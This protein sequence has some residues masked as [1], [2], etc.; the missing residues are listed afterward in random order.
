MRRY[1]SIWLVVAGG[2]CWFAIREKFCWLAAVDGRFW[3]GTRKKHCWLFDWQARWTERVTKAGSTALSFLSCEHVQGLMPTF[4]L[5]FSSS[6]SYLPFHCFIQKW[7]GSLESIHGSWRGRSLPPLIPCRS[8]PFRVAVVE[9]P[10]L[11]AHLGLRRKNW[12]LFLIGLFL[13]P[14]LSRNAVLPAPNLHSFPIVLP[15]SPVFPDL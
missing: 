4:F 3:F 8:A 14:C 7:R 1:C 12:S 11:P 10:L 5:L 9:G 15:I 13:F 6:S 2:W